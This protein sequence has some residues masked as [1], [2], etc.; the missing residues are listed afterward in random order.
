MMN[1]THVALSVCIT[2][3]ALSTADPIT[4]SMAAIASQLPDVDTS[5]SVIGRLLFPISNYIEARYPHRSITH[6]FLATAAIALLFLPLV[7]FNWSY[8]LAVTLGYFCG[9][10]GDVFTK[11]GV[12][13][14]YPH[15]ARLVIPG[16][17]RL[18][19]STGSRS[20]YFVLVLIVIVCT[21][22]INISSSGGLLRAFN[23]ALA[24]P[25]GA[26]EITNEEI[27]RHIL[28]AQVKGR[29]ALTQQ[30]VVG[31]YEIVKSLTDT[32]LLVRDGAGKLYRIGSSQEAQIA[33]NS[34]RTERGQA[35]ATKSLELRLDSDDLGA[36]IASIP[37]AGRVYISGILNLEDAED[38]VLN[39]SPEQFNPITLQPIGNG[40]A[41]A[42]IESATP[43][44]LQVLR[45]YPTT[46]NLVVRI[47]NVRS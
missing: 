7:I 15:Q 39:T 30:P 45:D 2:S 28:I 20:E 16:N 46:G 4:L 42:R 27:N 31:N 10:F 5:K 8:W 23:Q 24:M 25:S 3:I 26:V 33:T 6:S 19:L 14:F 22:S 40:L 11:S 18:R 17:P 29:N 13:A 9:W 35:I 1:L 34:V 37:A 21:I 38:L 47:I 36:S 41:V 43:N 12:T 32:D 44:D